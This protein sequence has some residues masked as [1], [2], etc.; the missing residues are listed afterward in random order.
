MGSV[1]KKKKRKERETTVIYDSV[2]RIAPTL[3]SFFV[4]RT[5]RAERKGME[6]TTPFD[7]QHKPCPPKEKHLWTDKHSLRAFIQLCWQPCSLLSAWCLLLCLCRCRKPMY[8]NAGRRKPT[9][10]VYGK[11]GYNYCSAAQRENDEGR[12]MDSQ[13]SVCHMRDLEKQPTKW[14]PVVLNVIEHPEGG[15][16]AGG[17]V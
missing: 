4:L 9:L 7:R 10:F 3:F 12:R 13:P 2:W 1:E 17:K 11:G 16:E 14:H 5:T 8:F 15:C 6:A